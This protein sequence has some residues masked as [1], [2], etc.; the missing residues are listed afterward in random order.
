ML[1]DCYIV[2]VDEHVNEMLFL[3]AHNPYPL[4]CLAMVGLILQVFL[5]FN[6]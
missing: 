2:L 6:I 4:C 5:D 3:P 1:D